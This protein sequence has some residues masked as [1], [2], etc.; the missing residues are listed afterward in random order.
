VQDSDLCPLCKKSV[1][2]D[3]SDQEAAAAG[4][5]GSAAASAGHSL[6]P[7]SSTINT[8][9]DEEAEDAPLLRGAS[10]RTARRYGSRNYQRMIFRWNVYSSLPSP[11]D[12]LHGLFSLFLF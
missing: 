12:C 10:S 1:I 4:T 7:A 2:G 3:E 6:T 9:Q 11:S 8:V 5:S